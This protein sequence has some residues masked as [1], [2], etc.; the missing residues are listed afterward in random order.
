MK[1]SINKK[2]KKT[3]QGEAEDRPRMIKVYFI[4]GARK[5]GKIG[6]K[7]NSDEEK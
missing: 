3:K 6:Q 7:C 2:I 5:R 4:F 1:T